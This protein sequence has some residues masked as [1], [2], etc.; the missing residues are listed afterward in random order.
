MG[1]GAGCCIKGQ[2][3]IQGALRDLAALSPTTKIML[4]R[5]MRESR[6]MVLTRKE[7]EHETSSPT[8]SV[9]EQQQSGG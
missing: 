8:V 6:V 4:V 7:Y 5:Q 3:S 1:S 2:V 9:S